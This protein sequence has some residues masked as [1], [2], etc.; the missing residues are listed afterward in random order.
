[1]RAPHS[2]GRIAGLLGHASVLALLAGCGP[3]RPATLKGD[4]FL[5]LESGQEVSLGGLAVRLMPEVE[6]MDTVIARS[7]PRSERPSDPLPD[8]AHYAAAWR[9]REALL[10]GRVVREARADAAAHFHFDS[11]A[12]GRYRVWADTS[13]GG[14]RWSWL[15]PVKLEAGDSASVTLSNANP[16]ENP[17]RCKG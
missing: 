7:C 3:A 2:R 13:Y 8:S 9:A 1:M 12:P 6:G 15:V 17:F 10:R 5:V 14:E 4:G 16:D 11:V